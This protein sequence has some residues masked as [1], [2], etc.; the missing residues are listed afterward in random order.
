[1]IVTFWLFRDR[2]PPEWGGQ[3]GLLGLMVVV[4]LPLTWAT[5]KVLLAKAENRNEA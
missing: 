5:T 1:M 4:G 3:F 2:F